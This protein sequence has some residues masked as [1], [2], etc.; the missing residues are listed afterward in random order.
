MSDPAVDVHVQLRDSHSLSSDRFAEGLMLEATVDT[1]R[2]AARRAPCH[3]IRYHVFSAIL[4]DSRVC[5]IL[6]MVL[7]RRRRRML[8]RRTPGARGWAS[9][10]TPSPS[11]NGNS[12]RALSGA[13]ARAAARSMRCFRLSTPCSF[14]LRK[15]QHGKGAQGCQR[16]LRSWRWCQCQL[17]WRTSS[18]CPN[19][20]NRKPVKQAGHLHSAGGGQG[21]LTKTQAGGFEGDGARPAFSF[22]CKR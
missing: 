2:P 6:L 21:V 12:R 19:V 14:R 17:A 8:Q 5:T 3:S 9:R 11:T 20:W 10:S 4:S 16:T 1:A 13:W 22:R 18:V 7:C 15:K